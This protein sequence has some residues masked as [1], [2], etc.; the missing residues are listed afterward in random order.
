MTVVGIVF[1]GVYPTRTW[2]AQ[3]GQ[4]NDATHQLSVLEQQN[5]DRSRAQVTALNTDS[6]IE[7]LAREKYNLVRPGEEELHA[8]NPAPPPPLVVPGTWPF[9]ALATEL[10]TPG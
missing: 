7:R 4:L 10:A 6:E 9:G 3:R 8:I 5:D 2:F 1:I